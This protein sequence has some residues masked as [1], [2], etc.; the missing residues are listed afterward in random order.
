MMKY[1]E[2]TYRLEDPD[3]FVVTD[4]QNGTRF[5]GG[6]QDWYHTKWQ[7][8]SGCGPTTITNIFSY[9]TRGT[10][11]DSDKQ[12]SKAAHTALMEKIWKYVTPTIHGIPTATLLLRGVPDLLTAHGYQY[13]L[14]QLDIEPPRNTDMPTIGSFLKQY[15]QRDI[16]VALLTLDKGKEP[17]LDEWHWVTVVGM[18]EAKGNDMRLLIIDNGEMKEVNLG[19][20]L[21]T[22]KKG[23]GLAAFSIS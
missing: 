16:P 3:A 20:W 1:E 9:L 19:L 2:M 18:D 5:M 11:Q 21:A 13:Q 15:L 23:G 17:T 12:L 22:T 6:D 14:D 8:M 4:S 7:R 10:R